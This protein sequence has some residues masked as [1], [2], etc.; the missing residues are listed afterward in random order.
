MLKKVNLQLLAE[1][2]GAANSG[3]GTAGQGQPAAQAGNGDGGQN[4]GKTYSQADLDKIVNE[5]SDRAANAALLSYYQQ[6]GMTEAEAKQ[7]IADYKAAKTAQTEKD[8]GNLTAMQ[9]K[10]AEA[11]KKAA[12]I[13]EAAFA[14]LVEA[15]SE[16][17]A[18]QLGIDP[19]KLQYIKLDFSKVGKDEKGKPKADDI[20]AVLEGALKVMPEIKK[21]TEPIQS[22]VA[23]TNG[24]KAT[25]GDDA[26]LRK[27]M[28]LPEKK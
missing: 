2:A 14:D 26:A 18:V 4:A 1:G 22:G 3:T 7:A 11:E 25:A 17:I 13:A 24:G 12:E 8:K 6:N 16:A 19:A 23:A 9:Q 21:T 15:K 5:R 28:G 27:A 20:K 10:A